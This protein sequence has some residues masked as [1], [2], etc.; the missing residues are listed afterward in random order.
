MK[1]EGRVR[2]GK[3]EAQKFLSMEPYKEKIEDKT[4][5]RPFPGTL[6][7]EVDP[8][9][10]EEFK[11]EREEKRVE[12]FEH[13][14]KDFGGIKL[15]EMEIEGFEAVLLDIDRADHGEEI[16]EIVAEEKLRESLGLEDRDKVEISG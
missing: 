14:G 1:I 13:E 3:G 9:R 5:F 4:G 11:D 12:G 8:E 2:E 15:Y 6:N 7:V 16:A 10:I